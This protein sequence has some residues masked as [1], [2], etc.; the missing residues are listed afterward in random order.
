MN[1]H[2]IV[3]D[4]E[5]VRHEIVA[6]F[7]NKDEAIEKAEAIIDGGGR[8]IIHDYERHI[9]YYCRNQWE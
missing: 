4:K 2:G 1:V 3:S 5:G 7:D 9:D 8:A 6:D